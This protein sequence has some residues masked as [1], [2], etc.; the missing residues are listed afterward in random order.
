M[1]GVEGVRVFVLRVEGGEGL[2]WK[3]GEICAILRFCF[4]RKV[5]VV[6]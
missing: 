1:P 2:R 5:E 4:E 6:R 3:G